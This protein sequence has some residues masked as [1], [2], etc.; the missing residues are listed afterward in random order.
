MES[1]PDKDVVQRILG[2]DMESNAILF[3][4]AK[5]AGLDFCTW[6][7]HLSP[8]QN[9]TVDVVLEYSP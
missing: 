2:V 4:K 1:L 3:W 9:H 5:V 7:K 6:R 8:D